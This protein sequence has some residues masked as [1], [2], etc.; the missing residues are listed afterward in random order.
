[1]QPVAQQ[2]GSIAHSSGR[3]RVELSPSKNS[4]L[5][6]QR[7]AGVSQDLGLRVCV[8]KDQFGFLLHHRVMQKEMDDQIAVPII[9]E[10]KERFA[11]LISCNFDKGFDSPKNHADLAWVLDELILPRKGKLF[12]P[13]KDGKERTI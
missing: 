2:T 4:S 5:C 10:T 3:G 6:P 11:Q 9:M 7:Q 1:M 12:I 13:T 8:V